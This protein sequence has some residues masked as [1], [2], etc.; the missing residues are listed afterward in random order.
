MLSSTIIRNVFSK[1]G[2]VHVDA[3]QQRS[4]RKAAWMFAMLTQATS[5]I[6]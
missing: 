2:T 6:T 3:K 1:Y 5:G 4:F